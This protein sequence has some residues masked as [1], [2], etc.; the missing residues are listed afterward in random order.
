MRERITA[1]LITFMLAAC[2]SSGGDTVDLGPGPGGDGCSEFTSK[3]FTEND[4]T[5]PSLDS[6]DGKATIVV[7]QIIQPGTRFTATIQVLCGF[8]TPPNGQSYNGRAYLIQWGS[9]VPTHSL[10]ITYDLPPPSSGLD[11]S[12]LAIGTIDSLNGW[13]ALN[14]LNSQPPSGGEAFGLGL[15]DSN[16]TYGIF[17]LQSGGGGP[18]TTAPSIPTNVVLSVNSGVITV[19]WTASQD[20]AGG[21]GV[22]GYDVFRG[23]DE[24]TLLQ[25]SPSPPSQPVLGTSYLDQNVT[26]GNRYC[27]A[28][29]SIDNAGNTSGQSSPVCVPLP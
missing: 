7:T 19:R 22:K 8:S 28:V 17:I 24:I 10:R 27:Y 3:T 14:I 16:V 1:I 11:E 18:D 5:D 13:Q 15:Q 9:L 26:R 25:I 23:F 6:K 4:I 29:R 21:S 12:D 2:G 20:E